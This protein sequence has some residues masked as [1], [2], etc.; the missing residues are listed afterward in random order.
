MMKDTIEIPSPIIYPL[1]TL[2][3]DDAIGNLFEESRDKKSEDFLQ[4]RPSPLLIATYISRV[5]F[6]VSFKNQT[7]LYNPET[8]LYYEDSGTIR[9][10]VQL[11]IMKAQ[12]VFSKTAD[13]R[14]P[15]AQKWDA[16]NRDINSEV[17]VVNVIDGNSFPFNTFNGFPCENCVITFEDDQKIQLLA[18]THEMRFTRKIP[19]KYHPGADTKKVLDV[20]KSWLP[21]VDEDGFEMYEWLLQIPAQQSFSRFPG[22]NRS[23]RRISF[24]GNRMPE[25]PPIPICY[26][27]S[28]E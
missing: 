3:E 16:T 4:M 1:Q 17:D 15:P 27:N 22:L 28:S 8:S 18:Y 13:R 23:R 6:P 21:G 26:R 25:K 14:L 7:Y 20:L 2:P 19:V 11:L 9:E 12:D 24:S 10:W 5:F